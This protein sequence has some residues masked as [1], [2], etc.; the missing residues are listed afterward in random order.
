MVPFNDELQGSDVFICF[1]HVKIAK[2]NTFVTKFSILLEN[3]ATT[4]E[5]LFIPCV[6]VT[7]P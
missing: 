5:F 7:V 6:L 4:E 2:E 3:R 1:K